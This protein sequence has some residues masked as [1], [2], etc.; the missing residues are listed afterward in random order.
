MLEL[1]ALCSDEDC[2]EQVPIH[3]NGIDELDR[4]LC[5]CDCTLVLLD[6]AEVVFV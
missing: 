6:A 1:T 5:E 3:V 2:A 4:F